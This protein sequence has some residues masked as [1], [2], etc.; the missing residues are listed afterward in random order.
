MYHFLRFYQPFGYSLYK[1]VN[2]CGNWLFFNFFF[3][4]VYKR[5]L[6]NGKNDSV[7]YKWRDTKF[8]KKL[9][10]AAIISQI[11]WSVVFQMMQLYMLSY[12]LIDRISICLI[13]LIKIFIAVESMKIVDK[14]GCFKSIFNPKRRYR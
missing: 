2:L 1:L 7:K 9:T 3:L 13:N 11:R 5:V 8:I 12:S 4:I 14:V 10:I 6:E